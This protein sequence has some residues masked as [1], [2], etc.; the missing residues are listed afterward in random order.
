MP[1]SKLSARQIL[2]QQTIFLATGLVSTLGAQWLNYQHAADSR[3]LLTVL[4]TYLG[5]LRLTQE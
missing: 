2:F 5:K 3:S 4:C 1:S